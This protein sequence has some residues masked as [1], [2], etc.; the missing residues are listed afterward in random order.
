MRAVKSPSW[1]V[2]ALFVAGCATSS[3]RPD[4]TNAIL[5]SRK[6]VVESIDERS[7]RDDGADASQAQFEI[8]PGRHTLEVTLATDAAALRR[9]GE[10]AKAIRVCFDAVAGHSYVTQPL[11]EAGQWR[12]EIV[13]RSTGRAVASGCAEAPEPEPAPS[14]AQ[15]PATAPPPNPE[16]DKQHSVSL[17]V[18]SS[19]LVRDS[20]LP[21]TG[22][23]A[24]VG[25]F[26]GGESLYAV[27]FTNAPDRNLSAGRGVLVA[28]GGL[29]TPLWLDDRFGFGVGVQAGWKYDSIEASNGSISLT[30]FP[31]STTVH[32]LIR[33]DKRWFTLLSVGLTKEVAASV[34]GSGFAATAS[35]DVTNSLGLL[36]EGALYFNVEHATL[37]AGVRY[38]ASHDWFQYARFD[39][40]S[41]GFIASAQYN[42]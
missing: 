15:A 1:G 18:P 16:L 12:P 35:G 10:G 6:T 27:S 22:L 17:P 9:S 5:G 13:D 21:G 28:L 38:S 11:F 33:I 25:F 7:L 23:V 36:G 37:G 34:S 8:P 3:S 30:R 40:S 2:V 19:P 26:F 20:N 14:A 42:F 32:S 31:L 24:G 4:T 29:W 39:A 41:V